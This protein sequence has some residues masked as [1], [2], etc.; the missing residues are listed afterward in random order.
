MLLR[1]S[2]QWSRVFSWIWADG[3]AEAT[4]LNQ[5]MFRVVHVPAALSALKPDTAGTFT[6]EIDASAG[7]ATSGQQGPHSVGSSRQ[8][9]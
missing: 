3:G 1:K 7:Q 5:A 9:T 4:L 6:L 8:A 2:L